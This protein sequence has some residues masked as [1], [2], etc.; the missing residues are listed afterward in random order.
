MYK[1]AY[2]KNKVA[3]M[4]YSMGPMETQGFSKVGQ[5]GRRG[6]QGDAMDSTHH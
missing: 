3:I 4:D 2:L 6:G 5:G 1:L